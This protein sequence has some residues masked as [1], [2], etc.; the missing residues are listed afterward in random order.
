MVI[1]TL[2]PSIPSVA[3]QTLPREALDAPEALPLS[4]LDLALLGAESRFFGAQ[5]QPGDQGAGMVYPAWKM[6]VS[7]WFHGG[8]MVVS[9]WFHGGFNQQNAGLNGNL[10]GLVNIQKAIEHGHR[11]GGFT[12]N[13]L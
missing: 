9:W 5:R 1:V 11:N 6:V 10:P 8:L 7:W 4:V 13:T 2:T 12:H 3:A